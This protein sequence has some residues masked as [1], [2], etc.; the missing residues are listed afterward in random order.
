MHDALSFDADRH[1]FRQSPHGRVT[2]MITIAR[3][4]MPAGARHEYVAI[5]M[6]RRRLVDI[7][8]LARLYALFLDYADIYKNINFSTM[9][10][11]DDEAI[12]KNAFHEKL[13]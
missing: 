1:C 7:L 6:T 4:E 12:Y 9:P 11:L 2:L 13:P 3:D 5:I 10:L 8:K